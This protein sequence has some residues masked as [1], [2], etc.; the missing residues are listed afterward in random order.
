MAQALKDE[1]EDFLTNFKI[2]IVQPKMLP[3]A[4]ALTS[5]NKQQELLKYS[6]YTLYKAKDD[7]ITFGG[8]YHDKNKVNWLLKEGHYNNPESIIKEYVAGGI[9]QFILGENAPRTEIVLNDVDHNLLIGSKL[10]DN[11]KTLS[12]FENVATYDH[13]TGTYEPYG[14]NFPSTFNGKPLHGFMDA[15]WAINFV[16]DTD[17]HSGNVGLIDHGS[18]YNFA[19]IDH[20][21]SFSFDYDPN[22]KNETTLDD[23]RYHLSSF[24][25]IDSLEKVGFEEIYQGL[26]HIAELD[27]S[28][29]ESLI[30]DKMA[31]V[32][33]YM[34]ALNL[35]DLYTEF[36][37]T[38]KAANL[39]DNLKAYQEYIVCNL[40]S[41]HDQFKTIANNMVLEKAII[42]H[43]A[44]K[45]IALT[46]NGISL[47]SSFKPFYDP[48]YKRD[49]VDPYSWQLKTQSVTGLDLGQKYW[50][51]VFNN[52][53][54]DALKNHAITLADVLTTNINT[55]L[56]DLHVVDNATIVPIHVS[57]LPSLAQPVLL[58]C[59]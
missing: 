17:A 30:A 8:F 24:Y 44:A 33:T 7:G 39:D 29:I 3:I 10:L 37:E 40:K 20:G 23:I 26:T 59:A 12:R 48:S 4:N 45:L 54:V 28:N 52:S 13:K 50:P 32:K 6:D 9:Y 21:F 16:K 22:I 34:Q 35:N 14:S 5:H 55:T 58:D 27:F 57:P 15:I 53:T 51:E 19:K 25:Q 18:H 41:E 43:D 1:R 31:T 11:F 2:H 56:V 38:P 46:D 42:S 49:R 36:D 47:E